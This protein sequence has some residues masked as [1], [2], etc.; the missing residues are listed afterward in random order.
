MRHCGRCNTVVEV[1]GE[2]LPRW[3]M[4]LEA[5]GELAHQQA[6]V[7]LCKFCVG[8]LSYFAKERVS[9]DKWGNLITAADA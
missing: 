9:R 4:R 7:D 3:W 8:D 6:E 1:A 5:R 2:A